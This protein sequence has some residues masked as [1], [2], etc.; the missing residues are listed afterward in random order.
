MQ[1]CVTRFNNNTFLENERFRANNNIKCIY[2]SPVKITNNILPNEEIIILEM[3]NSENKIE[4]IGI[5]KNKLFLQKKYRIYSDNNYNRYVYKSNYRIDKNEF[6][7]YEII[8]IKILENLIFKSCLH[9]K[10]GHGIQIIPNY[11]KNN[12]EINYCKILNNYIKLRY[13]N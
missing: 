8:I 7:S 5:I 11:I 2:S 4:G 9:C 6:T 10:R 3:N 12:K 1:I 13:N